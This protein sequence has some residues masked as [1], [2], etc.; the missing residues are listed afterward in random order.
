MTRFEPASRIKG[1]RSGP[2]PQQI[3]AEGSELRKLHDLFQ[4]RRGEAIEI[5][6]HRYNQLGSMIQNLI[7]YYGLDIRL[8]RRGHKERGGLYI[9]AGEW[10]GSRYEDYVAARI[11]ASER[12]VS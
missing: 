9:L 5:N 10:F 8:L 4:S 11:A 1:H 12:V 3:P 2:V 6:R 7:D